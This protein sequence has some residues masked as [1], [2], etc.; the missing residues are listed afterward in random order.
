MISGLPYYKYLNVFAHT[1]VRV[2]AM[3]IETFLQLKKYS[4]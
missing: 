4:S 2:K 3:A 1:E